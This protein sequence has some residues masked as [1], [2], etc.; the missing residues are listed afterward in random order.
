MTTAH[1]SPI[2]LFKEALAAPRFTALAEPVNDLAPAD[3]SAGCAAFDFVEA[4]N[5]IDGLLAIRV[6]QI[7]IDFVLSR[8]LFTDN[9]VMK[10]PECRLFN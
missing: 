5:T 8:L 10:K 9:V 4:A 2:G 3:L 1:L 6:R 7:K